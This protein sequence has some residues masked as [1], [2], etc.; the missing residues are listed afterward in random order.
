MFEFKR[1]L[2]RYINIILLNYFRVILLFA[3]IYII[4]NLYRI[5]WKSAGVRYSKAQ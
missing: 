4:L 5:R 1:H 3:T 2:I